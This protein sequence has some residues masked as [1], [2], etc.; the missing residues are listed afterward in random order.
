MVS[1]RSHPGKVSD[2]TDTPAKTTPNKRQTRSKDSSEPSSPTTALATRSRARSVS[3]WSHTPSTLT[4]VWLIVSLPLVIWDTG[5]VLLRPWSMP[6][7]KLHAPIWSPYKLY[8]TVDYVYGFPAYEAKDG[9]TGAQGT[10]NAL[11]TLL[12]MVYLGIAY[13]YGNQESGVSGR[14]APATL[15]GRRKIVGRE[16]SL[17][18]LIGF[19]TSIMTLSKTLLYWLN[20]Y[21]SGFAHIGHNDFVSLLFL[22]IIPNGAWILFPTYMTYVFGSE[23]FQGL[24]MAAGLPPKKFL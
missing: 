21:H 3:A 10:V 13:Y 14:G 7:G 2:S 24:E 20:E 15:L 5:Y 23:I 16:A 12:Y 4:L 6:G 11:E 19:A 1:T 22:W 9:F 17:A 8:G 18:V